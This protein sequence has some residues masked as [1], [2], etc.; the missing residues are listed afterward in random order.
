L[1]PS[2][3]RSQELLDLVDREGNAIGTATRER[4]HGEGLLHRAVHA[5]VWDG[6]GRILL[7]L[8][9]STKAS[10]PGLWD[11]SVGGHVGAGEV[12]LDALLR[13]C[14]EEIGLELAA[15][16]L[17]P[18]GRHLFDEGSLDPE[19]VDSWGIVHEGPFRPDHS[20]VDEVRWFWREEVEELNARGASTPHFRTQWEL[21]LRARTSFRP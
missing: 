20:E 2:T 15:A 6:S 14:R 17:E 5:I 4:V 18:L 3:D 9:S 12:P 10:C 21:S 11:T 16:D 1:N 7:Q 19:L 13:E 8:R